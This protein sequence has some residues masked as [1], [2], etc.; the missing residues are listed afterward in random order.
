MKYSIS[1]VCCKLGPCW[2]DSQTD[3]SGKTVA[4]HSDESPRFLTYDRNK[5]DFCVGDL[6]EPELHFFKKILKIQLVATPL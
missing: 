1:A 5:F 4:E 3:T 6:E 2:F